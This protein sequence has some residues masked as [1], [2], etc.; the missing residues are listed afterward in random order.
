MAVSRFV[1]KASYSRIH[2]FL[3]Y[4]AGYSSSQGQGWWGLFKAPLVGSGLIILQISALPTTPCD[5]FPDVHRDGQIHITRS[6]YYRLGLQI[7]LEA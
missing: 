1:T 7:S 4:P 5:P 6:P 2:D 3:T